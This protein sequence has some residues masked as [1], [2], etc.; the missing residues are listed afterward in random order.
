MGH[1]KPHFP[2]LSL[3]NREIRL[4]GGR[5]GF[6][7]DWPHNHIKS[8]ISKDFV[9]RASPRGQARKS[10]PLRRCRFRT[11]PE[12]RIWSRIRGPI[13]ACVSPAHFG[14]TSFGDGLRCGTRSRRQH[15]AGLM[16]TRASASQ[17]PWGV[18]SVQRKPSAS[19][20]CCQSS[21]R[22]RRHSCINAAAD[23]STGC[24]PFMI[25]VM[26]S[27]ARNASRMSREA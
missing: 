9:F 23:S 20:C 21:G 13:P 8:F 12:R 16:P 26:I 3:K 14:S 17:A 25:A 2:V 18:R 4:S 24:R 22:P 1:T 5:D 27:G 15:R 19:R 6:A 11:A 10:A 7:R